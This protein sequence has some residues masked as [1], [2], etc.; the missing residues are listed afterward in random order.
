MIRAALALLAAALAG[1]AGAAP[2]SLP[3][4][5]LILDY[6]DARWMATSRS[7]GLVLEPRDCLSVRCD[8]GTGVAIAIATADEPFPTVI[9]RSESGFVD[10]LWQ[11]VDAL[12]PWPGEGAIREINGLTVFATDRWSGC[13]AMSPSELTA[14]IDHRGRRY[15]LASGIASGCRGV[16]GVGREAFVEILSGLRPRP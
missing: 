16:W 9:P 13:R 14:V 3:I 11:F 7:G 2:A 15:R 8:E 6:D 1:P 10:P 12:P 4:G 5:D